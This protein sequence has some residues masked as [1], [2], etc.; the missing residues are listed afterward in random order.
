MST[1]RLT[2]EAR[3]RLEVSLMHEPG[4]R[5]AFEARHSHPLPQV[6]ADQVLAAAAATGQRWVTPGQSEWP[7]SLDDLAAFGEDLD[8]IGGAMGAPLGLWVRGAGRLDELAATAIAVVGARTCTTYGA[9]VAGDLAADCADAGFTI[10]S[11]AAFGID[12][13]AHR[14]ALSLERPTI[15]VL[16]CGTDVDYPRAHAAM[17]SRIGAEG[18][19][20]S[21]Y[22]PGT[23]PLKH[24]FLARNR[25]IAGLS[26]AVVVV[27]AARRSGSLNTLHWADQLGRATMAVPGPV[28]SK[29]SG[30]THEAIRNGKS[31]L[32]T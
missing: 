15:A 19:I 6:D 16:A 25:L 21:E 29:Q 20:V 27:E 14:G 24:R 8:P 9:E 13:Q 10:I 28:T 31:V 18:L 26:L 17:L 3:R 30:G 2:R 11:G 23:P 4:S 12:A 5:S 22:P 1:Q 32:V 7:E